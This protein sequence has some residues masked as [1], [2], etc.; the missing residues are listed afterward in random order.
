MVKVSIPFGYVPDYVLARKVREQ[1][2]AKLSQNQAA[3]LKY[4][5]TYPDSIIGEAAKSLGI[6]I[7]GGKKW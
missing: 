3:L 1:N 7:Q 4:L 5:F 6:S 2:T